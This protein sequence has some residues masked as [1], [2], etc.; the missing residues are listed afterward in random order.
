MMVLVSTSLHA[1]TGEAP[2]HADRPTD[3]GGGENKA[4][5]GWEGRWLGAELPGLVLCAQS[6]AYLPQPSLWPSASGCR[7]DG[8][9]KTS[10]RGE[11]LAFGFSRRNA[12]LVPSVT[13]ITPSTPCSARREAGAAPREERRRSCWPPMGAGCIGR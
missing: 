5:S 13:M 2:S 3:S 6:S 8:G 12:V 7:G 1:F 9:K 11:P 10:V 4:P